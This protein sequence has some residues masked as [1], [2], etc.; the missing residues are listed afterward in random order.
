M[1]TQAWKTSFYTLWLGQAFSILSSSVLQ[2][3]LIWHLSAATQSAA[4]LSLAS[5]AGFLPTAILGSFAGVWVDRCSRKWV[6]VAADSFIA[7][8]SLVLAVVALFGPL[9][10][11]LVLLVLALRSVGAA[12]HSPA[13][14]A[15][16]PLLVPEE[17]LTKCA[18]MT[19]SLQTIGYMVGT[20]L[21]AVL[22]P[23]WSISALVLLDVAGA[24]L[25][26]L[27]V[28]LAKIPNAPK[29]HSVEKQHIWAE[30][31]AGYRQL[32]QHRGL[33]SLLWLGAIFTFLY[34][35]INAL[36]P[37]L[38]FGHFGGTPAQAA[39]VEITFSLGML[40][41]GAALGVWG[42]FRNRGMSIC[43][44]L[45]LM[46]GAILATGLLPTSGFASFTAFCVVMG[47]SVPLYTGPQT[48]LM[49]ERIPGEYLGRVF[50]LYGSILALSMPLGLALSGLF[51]DTLGTAL[52]FVLTGI[53][54]LL[55]AALA[56]ALPSIR[57]IDK[58]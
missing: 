13:I 2:M 14:S 36:F 22:F 34:A 8:I 12:F 21:A 47:L 38:T 44:A 49:Q 3:A 26:C 11:G 30:M 27:A 4:V 37:L 10:V 23:I 51:A 54:N 45:L 15:V 48:A 6:M 25:G 24:L 5:I 42:G 33:F 56:L 31:K 55:L 46:G 53:A 28:V 16:T 18:G 35:P 57:N 39:L 17:M 52:W 7:L 41:G 43:L 29:A 50:G 20:A 32:R 1:K 40:A 19:Q 9:P 58:Q